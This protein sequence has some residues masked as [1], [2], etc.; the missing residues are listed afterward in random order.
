MET[1]HGGFATKPNLRYLP[2]KTRSQRSFQTAL[3]PDVTVHAMGPSRDPEVIRDMDPPKGG[4]FELRRAAEGP[5][6]GGNG[7]ALF[8]KGFEITG[9]ARAARLAELQISDHDL[10][11]IEKASDEDP[12]A[13]AVQLDKAVN[14][15]SLMLMFEIGRAYLLFPG[16]AQWGTW[17]NALGDP[18]F[19]ALIEKTNFLKVG[20]HGSHNATP[21]ALVEEILKKNEFSAMVCTSETKKFKRIPLTSLMD[22]LD[23][24]AGHRVA[25]SDQT[26]PVKGFKRKTN[27]YVETTI[28][29]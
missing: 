23:E 25:R 26:T 8:A 21:R 27:V 29:I 18:E 12:F 24:K 14:G 28:A 11:A 17:Q 3:L 20:H 6:G 9:K 10:R 22:A 16:D 13:V 2:A 19:R 1:L 15:T 4:A 7:S 5:D